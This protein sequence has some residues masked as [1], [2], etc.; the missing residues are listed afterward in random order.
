[1]ILDRYFKKC[2]VQ[3]NKIFKSEEEQ[4]NYI[5]NTFLPASIQIENW[6]KE[7]FPNCWLKTSDE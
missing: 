4:Q 2:I 7:V 6:M 5:T 1:M 3:P